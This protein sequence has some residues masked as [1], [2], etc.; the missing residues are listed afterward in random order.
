MS[1]KWFYIFLLLGSKALADQGTTGAS[2]LKLQTGPR[3]IAMGESFAGL[4][5]DVNAIQYNAS[6]L[7]YVKDKE[8][9][10]MHAVWFQDMFYDHLAVA[11]PMEGIGTIGASVLYLNGGSFDKYVIDPVTGNPTAAGTFSANSMVGGLTYARE[12]IPTF[13]AGLN[14]KF[15]SESIDSSS[16]STFAADLSAMWHAPIKGL[17]AGLNIQNLGPSVGFDQTFPLPINVRLGVGFKPSDLISVD[18][19]YT[20]PIETAGVFSFGGEYGYKAAKT[21]T[22]YPRLGYK[23]QGAVDYNQTFTG[24]GPAVAAGL[25][26]GLGINLYDKYTFDYA[27][28]NYGFLGTPHRMSVSVKF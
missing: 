22:L 1:K 24:F 10:L 4:A 25:T 12:I 5:D 19:D 14:L 28:A 3:A 18:M 21:M 23:Y 27:Y 2:F 9:T 20:Q 7:S 26:M 16:T 17:T 11:W 8:F 6:G 15:I 13:S